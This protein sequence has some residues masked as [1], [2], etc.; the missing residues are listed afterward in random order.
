M[1]NWRK[2][3]VNIFFSFWF[4][5]KKLNLD[6]FFSTSRTQSWT[7]LVEKKS[8]NPLS[9]MPYFLNL[10]GYEIH[11][12]WVSKFKAFCKPVYLPRPH[13]SMLGVGRWRGA[14]FHISTL[15]RGRGGWFYRKVLFFSNNFVQDCFDGPHSFELFHEAKIVYNNITRRWI[16]MQNFRNSSNRPKLRILW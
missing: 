5:G 11:P 14:Q 10:K 16:F 13:P 1:Q 15:L 3:G 12:I 7:K 2:S 8:E 4:M 9:K 6:D